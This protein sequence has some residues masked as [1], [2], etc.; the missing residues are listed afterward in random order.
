MQDYVEHLCK[1]VI[2]ELAPSDEHAKECTLVG[3]LDRELA[4]CP[5]EELQGP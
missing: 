1:S 2:G 5:S 4:R 3:E